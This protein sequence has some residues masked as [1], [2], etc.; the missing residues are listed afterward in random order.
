MDGSTRQQIRDATDPAYQEDSKRLVYKSV[1]S[2]QAGRGEG[3]FYVN[4]PNGAEG[5]IDGAPDDFYPVFTTGGRVLFSSTRVEEEG[6]RQNRLFVIT[7]YNSDEAMSIG[8]DPLRVLKD[9]RIPAVRGDGL[10]A[11]TGCVGNKGCGIW[12]AGEDGYPPNNPPANWLIAREGSFGALDWAP[13]GSRLTYASNGEGG[14]WNIYI[15]GAG[16]GTARRIAQGGVNVAPAWSPDGQWIA[17]LSNRDGSWAA[18]A[19]S[20]NGGE[21]TKLFNLPLSPFDS[22]NRRMDWGL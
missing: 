6:K 8:P 12:L 5:R 2:S 11:Y 15:V 18:W 3:I 16:G 9:A 21:P 7:R 4:L 19:V 17:F 20:V 14:A 1:A 22:T 13:D 10:I